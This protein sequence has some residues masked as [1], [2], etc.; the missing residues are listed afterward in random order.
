LE[1]SPSKD[2]PTLEGPSE[3]RQ[4]AEDL[5]K[6]PPAREVPK[7][8]PAVGSPTINQQA[9]KAPEDLPALESLSNGKCTT[10]LPQEEIPKEPAEISS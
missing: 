1:S 8:L 6:D 4:P 5:R 3:N 9:E 7:D 2:E 10:D